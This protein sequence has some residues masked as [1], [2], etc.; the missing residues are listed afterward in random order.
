M[1]CGELEMAAATPLLAN[2][3]NDP[4]REV[5]GAAIWAL[6]QIGGN[7]A[8]RVLYD[9]YREDDEFLCEAVKEALEQLEF[10]RGVLDVALDDLPDA[11]EW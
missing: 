2:L 4:D 8:R 7:E 5:Q 10:M 11:S 3:V 6:G 1:A 9:C